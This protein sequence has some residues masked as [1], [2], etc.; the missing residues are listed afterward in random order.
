MTM[1]QQ[2]QKGT[3]RAEPHLRP[4]KRSVCNLDPPEVRNVLPLRE[5]PVELSPVHSVTGEL[6]HDHLGA[7]LEL[8]RV[9]WRPPVGQVARGVESA[10]LVVVA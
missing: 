9:L 10:A 1:A 7:P 2:N 4:L 6:V 3:D 5:L 8:F